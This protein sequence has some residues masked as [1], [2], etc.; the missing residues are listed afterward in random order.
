MP[1]FIPGGMGGSGTGFALGPE[2]NEFTSAATRNTYA[3]AN[4]TWLALYNAD[5][6]LWIHTGVNIQRRNVAGLAGRM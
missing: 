3:T 1:I 2:Q 4:P 5:R 6:S